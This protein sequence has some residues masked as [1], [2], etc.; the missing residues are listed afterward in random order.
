MLSVLVA[1]RDFLLAM[2]LAWVG[3]T[4]EQRVDTADRCATEACEAS[5][6]R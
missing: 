3:I 4:L 2:A 6:D 1:I 5:R